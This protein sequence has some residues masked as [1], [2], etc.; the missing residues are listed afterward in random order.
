MI[1]ITAGEMNP[2]SWSVFCPGTTKPDDPKLARSMAHWQE[3]G[4]FAKIMDSDGELAQLLEF[5]AKRFTDTEELGKA[6]DA[7]DNIYN[8]RLEAEEEAGED[9]Q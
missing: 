7:L 6:L 5:V 3:A 4:L 8:K 2:G 9:V 1:F